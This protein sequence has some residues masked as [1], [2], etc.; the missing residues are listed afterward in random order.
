MSGF[1]INSIALSGTLTRDPELRELNSGMKV[2]S[3]RLAYNTRKKDG[4]SGEW[5]EQPNFIDMTAWGG[6]GEWYANNLGKGTAVVVH[7]EL[8]WR[9]WDAADGTKRQSYDINVNS[10]IPSGERRAPSGNS[11]FAARSDIPTDDRDF[12]PTPAGA[13][14][15]DTDIP[16]KWLE[17][18]A[19]YELK[20]VWRS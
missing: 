2:C 10:L 11:G 5:I 12:Q 15:D 16:F 14:S 13:S 19:W 20:S 9:E 7:G 6:I 1:S 18:L 17:P 3:M 4:A 8:R